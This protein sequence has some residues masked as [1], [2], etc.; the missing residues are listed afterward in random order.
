VYQSS[1]KIMTWGVY[2]YLILIPRDTWQISRLKSHLDDTRF[3]S[4]SAGIKEIQSFN[5]VI[6]VR[7]DLKFLSECNRIKAKQK[8]LDSISDQDKLDFIFNFS[9]I[10]SVLN[11]TNPL[12]VKTGHMKRYAYREVRDYVGRVQCL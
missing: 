9:V 2:I 12:P 8:A 3:Y 10:E 11:S 7:D 5:I 4:D 1:V 6:N